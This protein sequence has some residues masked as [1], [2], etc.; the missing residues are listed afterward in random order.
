MDFPSD[1]TAVQILTWVGIVFAAGF[2]GYFGR[3]LSTLII[4]RIHKKKAQ[5]VPS[6]SSAGPSAPAQIT[7]QSPQLEI[8]AQRAKGE[9]KRAKAETKQLKKERKG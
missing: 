7:P 9:K 3:Y 6:Q 4:D 8:E 1:N 5:E 2:I